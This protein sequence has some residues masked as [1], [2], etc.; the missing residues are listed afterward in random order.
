MKN[1]HIITAVLLL[2]FTTSCVQ[3]THKKTIVFKVNVSKLEA[4]KKV[5]I[6]GSDTPLSWEKGYP[7]QELV[8]DSLYQ[9][10]ITMETG[11]LYTEF[12]ISIND[13]TELEGKENRKIYFAMQGDT[14]A[15]SII[16]DKNTPL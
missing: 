5:S 15:V 9:A 13:K 14:T 1:S 2:L 4:V 11:R 10:I 7:L 6:R 8:K 12:K 16:Y 3:K